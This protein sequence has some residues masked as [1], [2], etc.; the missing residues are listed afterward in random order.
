MKKKSRF[1][2][3]KQWFCGLLG[4]HWYPFLGEKHYKICILCGK[5]LKEKGYLRKKENEKK[6]RK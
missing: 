6:Y 1:I 5:R 3:L 4:H 2:K